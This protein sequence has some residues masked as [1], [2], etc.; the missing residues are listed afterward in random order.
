MDFILLYPFSMTP[1]KKVPA[2]DAGFV[3]PSDMPE[4]RYHIIAHIQPVASP[5]VSTMIT[6][7]CGT[8]V[9]T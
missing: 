8:M 2:L 6:G 5:Y 9:L 3:L 7:T 4:R 1:T